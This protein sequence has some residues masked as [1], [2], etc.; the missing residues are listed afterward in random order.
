META[1]YTVLQAKRMMGVI[2]LI[3]ANGKMAHACVVFKNMRA[4]C[5]CLSCVHVY[6]ICPHASCVCVCVCVCVFISCWL[7]LA[8]LTAVAQHE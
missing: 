2:N 6:L 3:R 8:L 1:D 4:V 7:M 5:V